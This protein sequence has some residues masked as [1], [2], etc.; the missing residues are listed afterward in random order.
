M[1]QT[2][3]ENLY[4]ALMK[5]LAAALTV[6]VIVYIHLFTL[7]GVPP[8]FGIP[9][10]VVGQA[11]DIAEQAVKY[12]VIPIILLSLWSS[13]SREASHSTTDWEFF[14]YLDLALSVALF[15]YILAGIPT[16]VVAGWYKMPGVEL[17][18]IQVAFLI[19]SFF[20]LKNNGRRILGEGVRSASATTPATVALPAFDP[21][22]PV[23]IEGRN[24][25]VL[26]HKEG[27]R[28]VYEYVPEGR[29]SL[30]RLA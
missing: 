24:F 9:A 19:S 25:T 12:A 3:F 1:K 27:H 11:R 8:T 2:F 5:V 26:H 15:V 23:P 10:G 22:I 18:I 13:I 14:P 16:S 30:V 17:V 28:L 7:N 6:A 29:P 20:D 21:S 4:G